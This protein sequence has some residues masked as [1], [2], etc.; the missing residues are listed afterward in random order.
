VAAR[1]VTKDEW[2][3]RVEGLLNKLVNVIAKRI[4]SLGTLLS[5]I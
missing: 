2:T 5:F 1:A 3:N 4:W